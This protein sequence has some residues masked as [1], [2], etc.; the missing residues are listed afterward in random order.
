MPSDWIA[1]QL[2]DS[3]FPAGAFAHSG[4]LEAA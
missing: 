1:W 2:C 3:A 4:G